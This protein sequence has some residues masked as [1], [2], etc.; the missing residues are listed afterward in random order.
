MHFNP[1][2]I[3]HI[4]NQGNNRQ[5]IFFS[6]KNYLFFLQKMRDHLLPYGDLLCY[7]LMPNHFHWLFYVKK[8]IVTVQNDRLR[9]LNEPRIDCMTFTNRTLN[10]SI[11]ILLRSYTRA[12]NLQENRSGSLFRNDTKAKDGW[13]DPRVLPTDPN[14]GM[15]LKDWELYGTTCF[16]YIHNNPVRAGLVECAEQ[17]DYSS[18]QD[19]AG[20]RKG[21]LCNKDLAKTL[22]GFE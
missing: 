22:L 18:A 6:H 21:T 14:Y 2:T 7:C 8:I 9:L 20:F 19:F 17:W 3:Y 15:M 5:Q 11:G 10:D 1:N 4:Y 16:R 13:K 12:I